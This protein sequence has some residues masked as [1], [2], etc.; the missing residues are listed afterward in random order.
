MEQLT[1][2]KIAAIAAIELTS[3]AGPRDFHGLPVVRRGDWPIVAELLKLPT[4]PNSQLT[5]AHRLGFKNT[6]SGSCSYLKWFRS[7]APK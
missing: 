5:N 4:Q 1:R 7:L 2:E 6:C 3:I